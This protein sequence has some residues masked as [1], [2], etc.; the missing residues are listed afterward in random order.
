MFS[1]V[2]CSDSHKYKNAWDNSIEICN[3]MTCE[4]MKNQIEMLYY[5]LL[6]I[7]ECN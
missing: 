3:K 4:K 7:M 6:Q 5:N 1:F 2:V